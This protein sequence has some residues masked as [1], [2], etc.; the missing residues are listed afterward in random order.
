MH[1][2]VTDVFSPRSCE[3]YLKSASESPFSVGVAGGVG[4]AAMIDASVVF[5]AVGG[6]AA[7]APKA[8]NVGSDDLGNEK[9]GGVLVVVP[10]P[11]NLSCGMGCTARQPQGNA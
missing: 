9:A 2:S 1:A 6:F 11:A 4:C 5:A 10:K 8:D 7:A 3:K